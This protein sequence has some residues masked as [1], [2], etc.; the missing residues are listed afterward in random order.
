LKSEEEHKK[1]E[2][3]QTN[4][5]DWEKSDEAHQAEQRDR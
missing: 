5:I 2:K 3:K 4:K 1:E